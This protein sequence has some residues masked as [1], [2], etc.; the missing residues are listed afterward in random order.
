MKGRLLIAGALVVASSSI[1]RAQGL[2]AIDP[3]CQAQN[4]V[5]QDACQKALD[6]F[7]YMAPQLGTAV[8]GGSATLGMGGTLGG[9]GHFSLG[10]RANAVDGSLPDVENH[11]PS[12][13]GAQSSAY[14]TKRQVVP[15]PG[16]DVAVGVFRGIPLG[17]TNVGGIDLI[18]SATYIPAYDQGRFSATTP[19]GSLQLGYGA[20][21]GLLQESL[22][23]PGVSV[24]YLKRDL[25]DLNLLASVQAEATGGAKN[26]TIS[27]DGLKIKTEAIR[28]TVS[29]NLLVFGVHAGVGQDTYKSGGNLNVVVYTP[30]AV[31]LVY[32]RTQGNLVTFGQT[33][34]RTNY[35]AGVS[36]NLPLVKFV[37]EVGQVSGGS[38]PTYNTFD[39]K[40]DESR[41]YGSAGLRFKL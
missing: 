22:L 21:V 12:T 16:A 39:K 7:N 27:V 10:V 25:P 33:M 6:L 14:V 18:A 20:R 36:L 15:A 24:S 34:K 29:K 31:P 19:N 9:L 37:A 3:Q 32:N 38:I 4:Q 11:S 8:A 23:V 13:N 2:S 5:T 41:V 26:D 30:T 40:A 28:L 35:F 1:A 17:I